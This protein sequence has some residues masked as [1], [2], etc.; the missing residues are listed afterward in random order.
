LPAFKSPFSASSSVMGGKACNGWRV[1]SIAEA[2]SPTVKTS[3]VG[4]K[5][6]KPKS[7]AA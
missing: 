2:A 7:P 3:K 4:P 5:H 1:W 6:A